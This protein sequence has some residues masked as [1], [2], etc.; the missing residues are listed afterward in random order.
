MCTHH[1][2]WS[3]S[4]LGAFRIAKDVKF[5]HADNDGSDQTA[6]MRRVIWVFTGRTCQKVSFLTLLHNCSSSI[7]QIIR[8]L[9]TSLYYPFYLCR[10]LPF[11]ILRTFSSTLGYEFVLRFYGPVSPCWAR[12]VFLTTLSLGRFS[13]L[14]SSPVCAQSA[15]NWQ[16][17]FLNQRKGEND[18]RNISWSPSTNECCRPGG[19]R[20]RNLL[21]TSRTRTQLSHWGLHICI[22]RRYG[23]MIAMS[24]RPWFWCYFVQ[25][26]LNNSNILGTM[27]LCS[28]QR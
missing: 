1:A 2:V 7:N 4:S 9:V 15:R 19:G 8:I 12:S 13:P 26:N 10:T 11:L 28:R 16:L 25:S 23:N 24:F 6:R 3:E 18:R 20:T 17:P 21:I 5:L 27:K 22:H 14:S